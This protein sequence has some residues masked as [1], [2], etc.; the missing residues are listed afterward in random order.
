LNVVAVSAQEV[1][2]KNGRKVFFKGLKADMMLENG[3]WVD[4]DSETALYSQA[5]NELELQKK[6][7]LYSDRGYELET[8]H[9]VVDIDAKTIA[10]DEKTTGQ[11]PLGNVVSDGFTVSDGGKVLTFTGHVRMLVYPEKEK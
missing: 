5:E 4:L 10:G 3:V 11:G 9:A 6:V 7:N 1:P 2:A 8:T